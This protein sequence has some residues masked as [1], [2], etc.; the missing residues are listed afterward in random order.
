MNDVMEMN[1]HN[2]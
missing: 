1:M 2:V